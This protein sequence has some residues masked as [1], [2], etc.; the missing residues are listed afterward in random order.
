MEDRP[1]RL[2]LAKMKRWYGYEIRVPNDSLLNRKVT[3][4]ASL[5]SGMQAIHLVEKSTGLEFG[6]AGQNMVFREKGTKAKKK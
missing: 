1:L 2:A 4:R 3:M 5:D 6:Y